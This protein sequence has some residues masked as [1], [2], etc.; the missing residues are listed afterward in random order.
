MI[1]DLRTCQDNLGDTNEM[2]LKYF[3][4]VVNGVS[5]GNTFATML[6]YTSLRTLYL[7]RAA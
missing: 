4:M 6:L 7:C 1:L 3:H 2:H 5:E